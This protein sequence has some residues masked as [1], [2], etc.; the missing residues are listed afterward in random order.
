MKSMGCLQLYITPPVGMSDIIRNP[1]VFLV[2]LTLKVLIMTI[3]ALRH[4]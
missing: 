2:L 3:D 4:F 1:V